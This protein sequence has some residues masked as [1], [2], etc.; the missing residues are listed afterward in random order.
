MPLNIEVPVKYKKVIEPA[1]DAISYRNLVKFYYESRPNSKNKGGNKGYRIIRPY[2]ILQEAGTLK[3]VGTPITELSKEISKRQPGHYKI[4]QLEQRL[5]VNGFEVLPETFDDAA[6]SRNI[7]VNT[8]ST[9]IYR[10]IYDDEDP[11]KVKAGWLKIKYI[12]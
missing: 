2:M 7:V 8:K 4:S 1:R 3:L 11:K 9:P 5:E 10:F 6:V 12:K